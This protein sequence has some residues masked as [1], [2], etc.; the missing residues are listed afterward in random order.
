MT[1]SVPTIPGLWLG[2]GVELP[3]K[4]ADYRAYLKALEYDGLSQYA[5]VLSELQPVWSTTPS[6]PLA[7]RAAILAARAYLELGQPGDA[8]G[9]LRQHA[10]GL[11][12]PEGLMLLAKS[13]EA[14][15]D[16]G[17]AAASYQRVFYEYPLASESSEAEIAL[18]RL[19]S[20][21][22]ER[23]PPPMPRA[24]LDRAGTLMR[25]SSQA[26]ARREYE[27][28]ASVVA[29]RDR[30]IA[31]VRAGSND[32]RLLATLEVQ[33]SEADAERLYLLH[34]ALRKSGKDAQAA[35]S[36]DDLRR[37]Y[38]DSPWR[39][40]ALISLGNM[41]LLR[42]NA[43]AYEPVYR[44]CYELA[45]CHWKLTWRQYLRRAANASTLLREHV[46]RYPKSEKR[47]AALYFLKRYKEVIAA[48]PLSY[49]AAL[50]R[51]KLGSRT[52]AQ[53][54]SPNPA[55]LPKPALR[56]RLERARLLEAAG[57]ADWAEFELKYAAANE[58][59]PFAAAL[60]LAEISSRRA[61]Y[62]QSIRYIKSVA[63]GYLAIPLEDAPER[64]WRLAFPLPYRESLESYSR[65]HS[66]DSHMLAALIRQES[67]FDPRA[68]SRAQAYGLT[69]VL[70]STGRELSRR[71]GMR[72]FNPAMLFEPETNLK[73]G[74][75]HLRSLLD[76]HGGS[77][78]RALAAYNAG[79]SR[80][81]T[82]L[83][84][85]EYREPAE[86]VE[87]IPFT[88]TRDYVQTVVRNADIY[89]RLYGPARSARDASH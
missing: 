21:L 76:R 25:S 26:K 20:E 14:A 33:S 6:S 49:Y 3:D 15:G 10:A 69:Q 5:Y 17:G 29:G 88:E 41:Y 9:I 64:F 77:W 60:A 19:R 73:L 7:G 2:K 65:L 74:T 37:K 43:A 39:L 34:S 61:A 11:P 24:M 38:P 32:E 40:Q 54:E 63:K 23:Y 18:A 1:L 27:Q 81:A 52:R 44:L 78:E 82:W 67:E 68:I 22:G 56:A 50:S 62:H 72:S 79:N 51:E 48:Y 8:V 30:D 16:G 53:A 83:T 42:N 80:V 55:F 59:Q 85:A 36:V 4:I 70:P 66:I 46:D 89:R 58:G 57:Y 87:T 75:L 86:F 13:L 12:K 47:S 28:I 71:A 31:L 35:A 84:W 45:Y